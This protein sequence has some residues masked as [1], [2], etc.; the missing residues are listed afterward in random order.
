[1]ASKIDIYMMFYLSDTITMATHFQSSL[2]LIAKN[3]IHIE[4]KKN[5][6]DFLSDLL[7]PQEVVELADRINIFK[8]LKKGKT[9]REI[10]QD[11]GI[12]VTTVNR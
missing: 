4:S 8:S 1:M 5:L 11:L 6:E 3:L 7:T 9:Q 12:S 2:E 10:A